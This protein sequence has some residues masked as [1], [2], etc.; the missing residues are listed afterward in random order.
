MRRFLPNAIGAGLQ[1]SP[2]VRRARASIAE[3]GWLGSARLAWRSAYLLPLMRWP[4][5]GR[6]ERRAVAAVL[7]GGRWSGHPYPGPWTHRFEAAF[8]ALHQVP[9]VVAAS[10]GATALMAAFQALGL[11]PGDEVLVPALTF[12]ASAT[13]A[14][15]LGLR[16]V[17]VDVDPET[18]CIDPRLVEP[19]ITPRTKAIVAVH[20]GD[21]LCD[22][23]ALGEI[24]ARRHLKIVED[25]AHAHGAAWRGRPAGGL[26]DVGCFSFQGQ[27]LVSAGEGGAITTGDPRLAA[28]CAA[29]VD[30]GRTHGLLPDQSV[31]G[32]NLRLTELQAALL[33]CGLERFSREQGVR[34]SRMERLRD[35]LAGLDG[36]RLPRRDPRMTSRPAYGFQ[37]FF[38]S[39]ACGGMPRDRFLADL[40][41]AGFPVWG[42][43]YE[44]VYRAAEYGL[45]D[46]RMPAAPAER[47]CPVAESVTERSLVWIPHPFFLAAARHVDRLADTIAALVSG[48][49][50]SRAG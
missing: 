38:E 42:P 14:Q 21:E 45:L 17:F 43:L 9:H 7:R 15:V 49:R 12:S 18:L 19:A 48:Y 1:A 36:I 22:M 35:R 16:V 29:A 27:K 11:L 28:A 10:S 50:R 41:E 39:D 8:G 37:F 40:R 30:C 4:R 32:I 46:P 6:A 20:L 47:R 13:A 26:G 3:R 5:A 23:D 31:L 34:T 2:A 33:C 25:C 44:P 24:A